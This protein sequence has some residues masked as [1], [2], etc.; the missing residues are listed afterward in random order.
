M[1]IGV[2]EN[3]DHP[4]SFTPPFVSLSNLFDRLYNFRKVFSEKSYSTAQIPNQGGRGQQ[5]LLKKVTNKALTK[6]GLYFLLN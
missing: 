3:K 6:S 4:F 1:L 2:G 5:S